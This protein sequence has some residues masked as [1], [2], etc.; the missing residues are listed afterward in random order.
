MR[1]YR[2]VL[3]VIVCLQAAAP[4]ALAGDVVE[5]ADGRYLEIQRHE[6]HGESVR[7]ELQSGAWL[8]IPASQI[9][10]I[11]RRGRVIYAP[12]KP[13]PKAVRHTAPRA[14]APPTR[15]KVI[16]VYSAWASD[17]DQTPAELLAALRSGS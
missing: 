8:E 9:D 12:A 7:L 4:F 6:L 13:M 15:H 16:K 3:A 10:S 1:S 2:N 14:A 11:E 17:D 5:F